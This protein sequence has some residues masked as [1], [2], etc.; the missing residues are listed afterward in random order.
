MENLKN[1]KLL[2]L[3]LVGLILGIFGI[4]KS[5]FVDNVPW[6]NNEKITL[7]ENNN[8]KICSVENK[9]KNVSLFVSCAGFLE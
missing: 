3:V 9:E 4:S 1:L 6:S 7:S 8:E 2:H 5:S